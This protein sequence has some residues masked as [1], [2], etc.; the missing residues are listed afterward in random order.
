[1]ADL[2][3][4]SAPAITAPIDRP[5]VPR[6]AQFDRVPFHH[7][8]QCRDARSQAE[9]LAAGSLVLVPYFSPNEAAN[10]RGGKEL[11]LPRSKAGL[12]KSCRKRSNRKNQASWVP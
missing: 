8:S 7:L 1:V 6:T 5:P 3:G 9:P 12:G 2:A 4:G 10:A 11:G